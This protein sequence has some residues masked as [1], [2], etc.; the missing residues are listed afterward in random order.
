MFWITYFSILPLSIIYYLKFIKCRKI[1]VYIKNVDIYF[2][3]SLIFNNVININRYLYIF[4]Y[5][6]INS[7]VSFLEQIVT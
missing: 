3:L 2:H 5:L 6:M 1:F 4:I 7:F